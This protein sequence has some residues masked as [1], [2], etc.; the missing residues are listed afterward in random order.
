MALAMI[1]TKRFG[2]EPFRFMYFNAW[3]VT[4]QKL[5]MKELPL[6]TLEALTCIHAI[7]SKRFGIWLGLALFGLVLEVI[8]YIGGTHFHAQFL[9]QFMMFLPLKEILFYPLTMYPSW[10]AVEKLRLPKIWHCAVVMGII[11][12]FGHLPYDGFCAR[13]GFGWTYLD[14]D[15]QFSNFDKSQWHGGVAGV[16]YG[17]LTFNVA[18]G[19]ACAYS[20]NHHLSGTGTALLVGLSSLLSCAFWGPYHWMKLGTCSALWSLPFP[21][22][23]PMK[24]YGRCIREAGLSDDLCWGISLLIL[25][26]AAALALSARGADISAGHKGISDWP[27]V[28]VTCA[29]FSGVVAMYVMYDDNPAG[30]VPVWI[31]HGVTASCVH[32]MCHSFGVRSTINGKPS[33]HTGK[34]YK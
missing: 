23:D 8:G 21:D 11:Q 25:L 29:Y 12:H 30:I 31:F 26:C 7:R 2:E 19:A 5:I 3:D 17:W 10:L 16:Y 24:W 6:L 32:F 13:S 34:K 28:F 22:G 9:V 15:F 14:A 27:M 20:R 33:M 4:P 1:M 18:S